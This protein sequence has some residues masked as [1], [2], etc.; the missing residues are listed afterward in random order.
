MGTTLASIRLFHSPRQTKNLPVELSVF[1]GFLALVGLAHND[2]RGRPSRTVFS[3]LSLVY[4]PMED[5]GG[6]QHGVPVYM[7]GIPVLECSL[8]AC[9]CACDI[10]SL[11]GLKKVL[12]RASVQLAVNVREDYFAGIVVRIML[13]VC[14][15]HST[16]FTTEPIRAVRPAR[17]LP[18]QVQSNARSLGSIKPNTPTTCQKM[19]IIIVILGAF[20]CGSRATTKLSLPENKNRVAIAIRSPSNFLEY[21]VDLLCDIS[22]S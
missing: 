2:G 8:F 1:S 4:L 12:A 21:F 20:G 3:G 18:S 6:P 7:N 16:V 13:R 10:P 17:A 15:K 19:C 5:V 14:S 11:R 9:Q 22:V